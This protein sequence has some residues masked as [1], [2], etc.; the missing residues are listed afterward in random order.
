MGKD[1]VSNTNSFSIM[2]SACH[3]KNGTPSHCNHRRLIAELCIEK[4]C[5]IVKDINGDLHI[6]TALL[7]PGEGNYHRTVVRINKLRA[8]IKRECREAWFGIREECPNFSESDFSKTIT[9]D[10]S[11]N[12]TYTK[13]PNIRRR[14]K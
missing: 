4:N 10:M 6:R 5:P 12:C 9:C 11:A 13:C 2:Q 1:R 7:K 14:L 8:D 3:H